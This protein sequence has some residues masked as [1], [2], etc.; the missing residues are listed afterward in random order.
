M[1]DER[2]NSPARTDN[3]L[4]SWLNYISVRLRIKLDDQCLKQDKVTFTHK[5]MMNIYIVFGIHLWSYEQMD[6]F[7]YENSLLGAVTLTKN[8]DFDKYKILWI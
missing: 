3:S 6:G 4:V 5:N 8:A 2:I 7:A 1:S